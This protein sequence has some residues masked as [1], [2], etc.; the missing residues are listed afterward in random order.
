[1]KKLKNLDA[2]AFIAGYHVLLVALLPFVWG[3][4][5]LLV[6]G[7]FLITFVIGGLSITAGYHR[8]FAH[9][10]YEAHPLLEWFVLVGS[11]L[12][13]QW[14]A[15][16]WAHDHRLH[17]NHVDTEKDPYSIEK[18][19][20]Y[21]HIGWLFSY[22]QVFDKKLAGDLLKNPRVMFQHRHYLPLA[23]VVNLVVWGAACL[24]VSPLAA[25][26]GVFLLRVF[27]LHHCTW[28][29]NSLAHT[30]GS[31]TYA[32]ELSA[33]DNALL[34]FVTFGE[35]YHNY[36]HAF[37]ADYRNG[38]RWYHF[39]P[40]KW[41]IW[42]AHKCGL[43]GKLRKVNQVQVLK[44]LIQKDRKLL[45]ERL[46]EEADQRAV[47]LRS[48]VESIAAQYETTATNLIRKMKALRD[49]GADMRDN[50]RAEIKALRAEL[51]HYWKEWLN[52]TRTISLQYELAHHH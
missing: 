10:S 23:I 42:A 44:T 22:Q 43:A 29:I 46:E 26:W 47:E 36:H 16:S 34:A 9:R 32:K 39:D 11:T 50:L 40:T 27:A 14:S 2:F 33:V 19:F 30:F 38:V 24:L 52:L 49:S 41:F 20:W 35:G 8:L 21:A 15:L 3:D 7:L 13:F 12:A 48:K 37:A 31:K 28:F 18:G 6:W 45:V 4:L 1:M 17:H 5:S 25:F 51:S